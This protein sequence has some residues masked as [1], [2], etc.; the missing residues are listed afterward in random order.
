MNAVEEPAARLYRLGKNYFAIHNYEAAQ[1]FLSEAVIEGSTAAAR[2]L[3]QVAHLFFRHREYAR[4]EDAFQVLADRGSGESCLYLGILCR[5]GLGRR[6]D[7]AQA[8]HYFNE[9]YQLG[10]M[11]GAMEAGLLVEKEAHFSEEAKQAA[12]EWL[13]IAS[14]SGLNE[15]NRH[16]GLLLLDN[17]PAHHAEAMQWFL[18][19]ARGGDARCMVYASDL[20]RNGSGVPRNEG[21]AFSLLRRA[22]DM[23]DMKACSILGD[24]YASGT[25]VEKDQ[26][27]A[28]MYYRRAGGETPAPEQ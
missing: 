26:K 4:A 5:D 23:G 18:K 21:L 11:R 28:R 15:A 7:L 13:A 16:I 1:D 8:F 25:Y 9:A 12:I 17:V 22:A 19:G 24:W 10:D 14:E 6:R 2:L 20:Y 27:I 3:L